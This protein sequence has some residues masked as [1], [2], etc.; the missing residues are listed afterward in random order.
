[1]VA[2]L[3][4]VCAA[5]LGM[6]SWC[7]ALGILTVAL[8]GGYLFDNVSQVGPFLIV[9]AANLVLFVWAALLVRR[10]SSGQA[11]ETTS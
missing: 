8:A 7:G 9:V 5:V 11:G 2:G 4:P 1:M 3:Q 6:W 10:S